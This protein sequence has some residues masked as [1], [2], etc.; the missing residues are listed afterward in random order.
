VPL[1]AD[2]YN[3]D[4][5]I[6]NHGKSTTGL[7]FDRYEDV[8]VNVSGSPPPPAAQQSFAEMNLPSILYENIKK[9]GY[10]KP[11]PIQKHA[12]PIGF[13]GRDIMATAQTGSGKTIAYLLP[14]LGSCLKR[15]PESKWTHALVVAPTRELSLQIFEQAR[16]LA[17]GTPA[18]CV[19]I[20]GGAPKQ[21]QLTNLEHVG[22]DVIIGT[23]GR[24]L[25]FLQSQD[26]KFDKTKFLVLDE[27]DRMLD[28]GFEKDIRG[29]VEEINPRRQILLF[30]ATFPSQVQGL[31]R[32]M[33]R[34]DYVQVAIGMIGSS[35]ELI[36]QELIHVSNRG[37]YS[38]LGKLLQ[39]NNGKGK[40]LVFAER[41]S[42]VAALGARLH[43]SGLAAVSIHGDLD[44]NQRVSALRI[45]TKYPN[46]ILVAT[47]VASRGLDIGNISLV[48]NYDLPRSI[49]SYVHRIGRTG[50]CGNRGRA[51]SFVTGDEGGMLRDV[52]KHL[53]H[54]KQ[55]IPP[56]LV[57]LSQEG[58][59]ARGFYAPPSLSKPRSN[60]TSDSSEPCRAFAHGR[61]TRGSDCRRLHDGVGREKAPP[62]PQQR[63]DRGFD[64]VTSWGGPAS[65]GAVGS[66]EA[67]FNSDGGWA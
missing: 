61:C 36:D 11:T 19:A 53:Q 3:Q 46:A 63:R 65:S 34:R 55:E 66:G 48:V 20:Y 23:P 30:S 27:A 14:L 32:G 44:Q 64:S 37:K 38:A 43:D 26:L 15:P 12:I 4:E 22:R 39:S 13:A 50:R 5:C 25:D 42:D 10:T 40:A 9:C 47:D 45:F 31:A 41:K 51:V 1:I 57:D 17:F 16:K 29:L 7:D 54:T 28:M 35:P 33:L 21:A 49:D 18:V 2:P 56:W 52:V 59:P 58:R 67:G 62:S 60:P 6:F 24:L 8:E